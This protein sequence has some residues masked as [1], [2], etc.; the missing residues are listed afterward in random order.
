MLQPAVQAL[1]FI[2]PVAARSAG[3]KYKDSTSEWKDKTAT[4]LP[5]EMRHLGVGTLQRPPRP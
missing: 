5:F 4:D 3:K 1:I 2:M